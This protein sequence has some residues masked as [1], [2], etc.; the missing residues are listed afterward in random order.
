MNTELASF[1]FGGAG[2]NTELASFLFDTQ[3]FKSLNHTDDCLTIHF[4]HDTFEIKSVHDQDCCEHVYADFESIDSYKKQLDDYNGYS[5]LNILGV[6]EIGFIIDFVGT[7]YPNK[8]LIPCYNEQN[9]WYSNNLSISVR[10]NN[11]EALIVDLYG[12][13]QDQIS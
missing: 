6:K 2:M 11:L 13:K 5:G 12:Y 4:E 1:L 10:K 8:V 3:H 9:G 7:Y